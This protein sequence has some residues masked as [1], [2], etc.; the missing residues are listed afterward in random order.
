MEYLDD[1]RIN[2]TSKLRDQ[3]MKS[4]ACITWTERVAIG[5]KQI[6]SRCIK[7]SSKVPW[8]WGNDFKILLLMVRENDHTRRNH[9]DEYKDLFET[10]KRKND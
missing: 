1:G 2:P 8:C 9:K 10:S 5:V 4:I 6:A 7:L 3:L